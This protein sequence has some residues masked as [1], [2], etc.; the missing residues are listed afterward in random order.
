MP[1]FLIAAFT[2]LGNMFFQLVVWFVSRRGIA[3]AALTSIIALI[4]IAINYLISEIDSLIG[5]V[6]PSVATFAN[7]FLPDNTSLCISV[8]V[9]CEIACT[10]YK[11][12]L[13][14]IEYKSRVLLA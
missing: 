12:T 8:I 4:G 14:L 2:S 10:G 6:L 7:A 5:S 13:K 3:F 11:L 1:Y 9:S